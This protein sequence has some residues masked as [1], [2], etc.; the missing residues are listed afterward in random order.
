MIDKQLRSPKESVLTPIA[1][2][3]LRAIHPTAITLIAFGFGLA[4]AVAAWQQL[5][6][7]ALVLWLL[8]RVL[9]G[10]DGTVARLHQKQS[11][12]GGYLDIVLD[13][14]VYT[15]VP[16]GLALG[17][18]TLET[19][20]ALAFLFGCFYV[21]SATWMYL[22]ALL[23]KRHQGAAT[24][25]EKTTVTMPG[26]LIE[27][28]ETIIFYCLFLLLPAVAAPLFGIMGILVLVTAGQRVVWSI[29]NL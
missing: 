16:L 10:L 24:Q 26:G 8:N 22:A 11:D 5:Y 19:Y 21:N 1:L 6:I 18:N 17:I 14:V 4:A 3:P 29:R 28:T 7:L 12:L 23:E 13:M 25:G 15:A 9:D 2:R 20:L 27:G